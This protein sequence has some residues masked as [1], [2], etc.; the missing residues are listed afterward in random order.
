MVTPSPESIVFDPEAMMAGLRKWVECESPTYGAESVGRLARMIGAE[1]DML[2]AEVTHVPSP[3][4]Y[5]ESIVAR[6]RHGNAGSPGVLLVGHLDTVHPAGTLGHFPC[7]RDGNRCYGPGILD[8]KGGIY[9]ALEVLRAFQRL[10]LATPLP[11]TVLLN[12]DEEVGSPGTR[13]LVEAEAVRNKYVLVLEPAR[14]DGGVVTGR[15]AVSRFNV[16]TI[17]R[18]SHSSL[19]LQEG[20][21]AIREMAHQIIAIEKMTDENASFSV[22]V[23]HGGQWVNCVAGSCTAEVLCTTKTDA[24]LTEAANRMLALEAVQPG[25]GVK[26]TRGAIRPPWKPDPASQQLYSLA[27]DIARRIGFDLPQQTSAGGSDANFTGALGVPT[28]DG[29][30]AKGDGAHTLTEHILVDGLAERARLMAGLLG[31]LT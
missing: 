14:R 4:G 19:N 9:L 5:G 8:M 6:L 13:S 10:A 30:G 12:G 7:R 31:R 15:H 17:G 1:L 26:V 2:G 20:T 18:P 27:R 23:V 25:A 28:L 3:R 16:E 11:V 21:S 24:A 22:G 29:L